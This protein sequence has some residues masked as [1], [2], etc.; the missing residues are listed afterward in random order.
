ME[1]DL[2]I[3]AH[4]AA[5]SWLPSCGAELRARRGAGGWRRSQCPQPRQEASEMLGTSNGNVYLKVV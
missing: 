4:A 3:P 1:S 2:H 5:G